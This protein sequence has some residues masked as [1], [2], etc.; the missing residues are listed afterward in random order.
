MKHHFFAS[1]LISLE[2][3]LDLLL[4]FGT[5]GEEA[6]Q[7]ASNKQLNS[8]TPEINCSSYTR[9][10]KLVFAKNQLLVVQV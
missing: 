8:L 7:S 10:T 4:A 5:D 9:G 1:S 3:S 6:L 2:P